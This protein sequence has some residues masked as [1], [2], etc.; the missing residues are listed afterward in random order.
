MESKSLKRNLL[1]KYDNLKFSC[2]CMLVLNAIL[3]LVV[4]ISMGMILPNMSEVNPS[5]IK[6]TQDGFNYPDIQ[7]YSIKEKLHQL[8]RNGQV[9][10]NIKI[11]VHF[12]Y[13]I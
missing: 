4:I 8:Y 5:E 11:K 1:M 2:L 13:C 3:L 9:V 7:C 6:S 10:N 12:M